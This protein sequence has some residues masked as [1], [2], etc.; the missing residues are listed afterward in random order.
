MTDSNSEERPEDTV[1][2]FEADLGL[3]DG[4][5]RRLLEEDDWSF[6]VKVY[7][8]VEAAAT[9][10]LT[11]VLGR[12]ELTRIFSRLE[13]S[14][15]QTGKLAFA[16][17]LSCFEQRDRVFIRELGKIRNKFV[18]DIHHISLTLPEYVSRLD[19]DQFKNFRAAFG[20]GQDP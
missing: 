1:R 5:Y 2:R 8:L 18:H 20:P 3:P 7:A 17:A 12:P 15:S 16:E 13:M 9:H 4:L 6:I 11:D 19:H 10:L 14:D